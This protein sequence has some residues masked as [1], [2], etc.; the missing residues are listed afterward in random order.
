MSTAQ[1][2]PF[3]S[4]DHRP[5]LSLL[6]PVSSSGITHS[7]HRLQLACYSV[8]KLDVVRRDYNPLTM[9]P[10]TSHQ[11]IISRLT[12]SAPKRRFGFVLI[13]IIFI[14]IYILHT[15]RQYDIHLY[16]P[17]RYPPPLHRNIT[18]DPTPYL[19][20]ISSKLR[21]TC[22][23]VHSPVFP[24]PRLSSAQEIRYAHLRQANVD[25]TP[26]RH[27][28][29]SQGKFMLVATLKDVQPILP[30]LF[31]TI[32]VLSS[33][34]GPDRLSITFIEG[35]SNDC[36]AIALERVLYPALL[37]LG[38]PRNFISIHTRAKNVDW[39]SRHRIELLAELR[40]RALTPLWEDNGFDLDGKPIMAMSSM[41]RQV[42][43][44]IEAVVFFNDVYLNAGHVLELLHQHVVTGRETGLETGMTTGMDYRWGPWG[45][46]AEPL[47]YDVWVSRTVSQFNHPIIGSSILTI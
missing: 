12:F 6:P 9:R 30:D 46:S 25:V 35:P 19:F 15:N 42:G 41:S 23:N 14:L 34:L 13:S 45:P 2:F 17:H 39:D 33:F 20:H 1:I 18:V 8:S 24:Y 32:V 44:D 36:S 47:F 29:Q 43:T 4:V 38:I 26:T 11:D 22:H 5:S 10:L 31:N 7:P 27:M 40:N 16:P 37:S 28:H 21:L 3:S